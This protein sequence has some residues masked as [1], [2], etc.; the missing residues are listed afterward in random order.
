MEQLAHMHASGKCV[1]VLLFDFVDGALGFLFV[2]A[3]QNHVVAAL[4]QVARRLIAESR[5]RTCHDDHS[6]CHRP[7]CN[8]QHAPLSSSSSIVC[9]YLA[10]ISITLQHT[11]VYGVVRHSTAPLTAARFRAHR[12]AIRCEHN[13]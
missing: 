1:G 12:N 9:I 5:A 4:T 2:S 7:T 13:L 8:R 6:P 11:S 10:Y 3:R